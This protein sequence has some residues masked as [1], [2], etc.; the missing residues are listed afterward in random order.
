[1]QRGN[2]NSPPPGIKSMLVVALVMASMV[3][4]R[5]ATVERDVGSETQVKCTCYPCGCAQSPPPP[6]PPKWPVPYCPPPPPAP[7]LYIVGAPGNLYPFDTANFPSSSCRSYARP[8]LVFA[9]AALQVKEGRRLD[10]GGDVIYCEL[11]LEPLASLKVRRTNGERQHSGVPQH[12]LVLA[13]PD[14]SETGRNQEAG[15]SDTAR[16]R[17]RRNT[18]EQLAVSEGEGGLADASVAAEGVVGAA[19]AAGVGAERIRGRDACAG[20]RAGPAVGA[21]G[22]EDAEGEAGERRVCRLREEDDDAS[23]P[24]HCRAG[25]ASS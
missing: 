15:E 18:D 10:R 20:R 11:R 19:T 12:P 25:V 24:F 14:L 22:E 1:M 3:A 16:R 17:R 13:A 2:P 4:G 8:T 23:A 9:V 21:V 6:P 7:Y 5:S